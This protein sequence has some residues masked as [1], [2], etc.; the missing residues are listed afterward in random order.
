MFKQLF[1]SAA[2]ATV[3]AAAPALADNHEQNTQG[4]TSN[5]DPAVRDADKTTVVPD[6]EAYSDKD[7]GSKDGKA[8]APH[9]A[10]KMGDGD[11]AKEQG[12]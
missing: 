6:K 1:V 4:D 5:Y 2:F 9:P 12:Q 11:P 3:F 10:H 7:K 8:N